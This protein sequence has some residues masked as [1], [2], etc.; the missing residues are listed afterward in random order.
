M[1]E[2]TVRDLHD[3]AMKLTVEADMQEMLGNYQGAREMYTSACDLEERA[4][5]MVPL[6]PESEP[7]RSIMFRSAATLALNALDTMR[8]TLLARAGLVGSPPPEI[9]RELR[10]VIAI[11]REMDRVK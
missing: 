7:T 10:N 4:A 1:N 11:A 8:A 3:Q 9:E 6:A 5:K 2:P